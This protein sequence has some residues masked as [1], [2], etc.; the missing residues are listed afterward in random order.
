[1]QKLDKTKYLPRVLDSVIAD[2]RDGRYALFEMKLGSAYADE[3]ARSLLKVREKL[4]QR[5]M[6]APSFMAVV[7]PGGYA[8][9]REDGVLV[10]PIT[11]LAP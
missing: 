10:L 4:D 8:L 11:C 2:K 9:Q 5:V 6:G 1:M 3:G 7:V